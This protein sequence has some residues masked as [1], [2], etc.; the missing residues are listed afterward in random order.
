MHEGRIVNFNK[1]EYN[2]IGILFIK[3]EADC[4]SIPCMLL[5]TEE[6]LLQVYGDHRINYLAGKYI[7][8]K[9]DEDGMLK[10][11]GR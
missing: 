6:A 7:Q 8:Y 2:N 9:L 4:K 10:W 3:T 11:I 5:P 1:D